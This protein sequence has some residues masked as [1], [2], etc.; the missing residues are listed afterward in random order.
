MVQRIF[1][2]GWL[3]ICCLIPLVAQASQ[4][5]GG[6]VV[7]GLPRHDAVDGQTLA[8]ACLS[9]SENKPPRHIIL[10][11]GDGMGLEHVTAAWLC[12]GGG[13]NITQLPH[14]ALTLT[15]SANKEI[16]D[17]A[18]AG[19]ALSCGHKANNGQVGQL[20]D[21]EP[22]ESLADFFRQQGKATGL[23]VTKAVT[24]A[25]PA[26]FYAH[27]DS[28]KN[29]GAIA[30]AL[31]GAGFDVVLGGGASDFA[32][33]QMERMCARGALVKLDAPGNLP[34][35]SER[36][37]WLSRATAQALEK[38]EKNDKGIFL[39]VEGSQIDMAAHANFLE[40]SIRETLDFDK[41]V[42]VVLEWMAKHPDT[43]LVITADHQTGGLSLLA[44]DRKSGS[45]TGIF[46]TKGHSGIAVPL[47]AAGCRASLFDGVIENTEVPAKIRQAAQE[48]PGN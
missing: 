13:L 42:G 12:N 22:V 46:T 28:R 19:T 1:F 35:A 26:S 14:A 44:G 32:A 33:G 11:I 29:T 4:P 9:E 17:S 3:A 27:T 2:K 30:E 40:E 24:D 37:D 41:A 45:V 7:S 36:G 43:L 31:A 39:M 21:G 10:M 25:T 38:L 5:E 47:Y 6:T 16:T 15:P 18:A 23:V 20:P 8:L 34:Y 48:M